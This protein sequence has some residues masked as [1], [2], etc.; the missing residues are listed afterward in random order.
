M[1]LFDALQN[2]AF[3][4]VTDVM[5]V[6]AIWTPSAGGEPITARVLFNEPTAKEETADQPYEPQR[7][8]IEYKEGDLPG[9]YELVK[10]N[11]AEA[12]MVNGIAYVTMRGERKYDGKTIVVYLSPD[13]E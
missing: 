7:S 2:M 6:E 3:N 1:S 4:T 10:R 9:L 12:I 5:G 13:E 11:K 8:S